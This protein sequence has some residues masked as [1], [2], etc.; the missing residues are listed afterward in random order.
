MKT[1]VGDKI[2][3]KDFM[4]TAGFHMKTAGFHENRNKRSLARNGNPYVLV[5]SSLMTPMSIDGNSSHV[6]QCVGVILSI[7]NRSAYKYEC[8]KSLQRYY[9]FCYCGSKY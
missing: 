2:E 5:F 6:N 7:T 1:E 9:H 3:N 4:K 8:T